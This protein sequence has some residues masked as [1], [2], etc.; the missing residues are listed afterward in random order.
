MR[1]TKTGKVFFTRAA[2]ERL[3]PSF[4][5]AG[6]DIRCIHSYEDSIRAFLDTLNDQTCQQLADAFA[7]R[8]QEMKAARYAKNNGTA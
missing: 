3:G 8:E 6:H 5:R 2:R 7:E 1:D 4:A